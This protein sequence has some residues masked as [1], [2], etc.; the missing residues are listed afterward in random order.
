MITGIAVHSS[1][2]RC[3]MP[4]RFGIT[5]HE[6][7]RL[8]QRRGTVLLVHR[9]KLIQIGRPSLAVP[10]QTVLARLTIYRKT[11]VQSK[12]ILT[13]YIRTISGPVT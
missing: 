10:A 7:G 13:V 3:H 5:D 12:A 11:P 1:V 9:Y 2:R 6:I 4:T 8:F